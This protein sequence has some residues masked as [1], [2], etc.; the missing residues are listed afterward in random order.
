MRRNKKTKRR[1][2]RG[3]GK[4]REGKEEREDR[5][6]KKRE[7]RREGKGRRRRKRR[8]KKGRA[9][10][11]TKEQKREGGKKTTMHRT[12][13]WRSEIS[14]HA[15]QF[16]SMSQRDLRVDARRFGRKASR[17]LPDSQSVSKR[18]CI[19]AHTQRPLEI[20]SQHNHALIILQYGTGDTQDTQDT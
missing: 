17:P 8:Q 2:K 19:H 14:R 16:R 7:R 4:G 12:R 9:T 3:E 5:R 6:K 18:I 10:R 15:P 13:V 1:E 11:T 20:S